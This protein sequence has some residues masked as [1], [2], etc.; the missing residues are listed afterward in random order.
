MS[1]AGLRRVRVL[2]DTGS[3]WAI[4]VEAPAREPEDL[5]AEMKQLDAAFQINRREKVEDAGQEVRS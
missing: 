4:L 2:L 1:P 3:T 5:E